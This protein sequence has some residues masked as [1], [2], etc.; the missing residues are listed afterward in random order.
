MT[1]LTKNFSREEFACKDGCGYADISL[2]LVKMLQAIRDFCGFPL[3]V[4]SG[5]RCG[6]HNKKIGGKVNSAHLKGLAVDI[7]AGKSQ[8]RYF[9]LKGAINIGFQRI[10]I[11]PTFIH[12][13]IDFGKPQGVI[14]TK[15]KEFDC[16][17]GL[18][19]FDR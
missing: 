18:L 5:C 9:I 1:K 11:Y 6:K 4:N 13:D 2:E 10:G 14:W 16:P 19:G 17:S 8:T 3:I 7:K 15:N 12:L